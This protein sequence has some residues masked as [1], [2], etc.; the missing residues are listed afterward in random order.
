MIFDKSQYKNLAALAVLVV[1]LVLSSMGADRYNKNK[2]DNKGMMTFSVVGIVFSI[3]SIIGLGM[4][5]KSGGREA[6]TYLE[7]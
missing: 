6:Q 4:Y 3:F 1:I 5:I 2:E 7:I